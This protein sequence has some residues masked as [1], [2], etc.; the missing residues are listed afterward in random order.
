MTK[1]IINLLA[2]DPWAIKPEV[3]DELL[4]AYNNLAANL[5]ATSGAPLAALSGASGA[6]EGDAPYTLDGRVAVIDISGTI[7]RTGGH[8]RCFSW[9]GQDDIKAAVDAAISDRRAKAILLSFDSPGGVV[10]GLKELADHIAAQAKQ[11]PMYAY[12]DGLC[13]SAAYWLAS[14][15]GRIY[16]PVTAT[17]GSIGVVAVHTDRSGANTAAGLRITYIT[18][19]TWKAAGNADAPLSAQDKQYYQGRIDALHTIFKADVAARMPVNAD[20]PEKWGDGQ[21]FLAEEAR[22]LGLLTGIVSDRQALIAQIHKEI[23]MDKAKLASEHP[24]LLAEIEREATANA[25]AKSKETLTAALA[26]QAAL[27]AAIAGDEM[28]AKVAALVAAGVTA[29]QVK[30]MRAAGFDLPKAE[31][32]KAAEA[33]ESDSRKEVLAALKAATPAPVAAN[34][35][36]KPTPD[37][38]EAAI[39]AVAD[40]IAKM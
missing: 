20:L 2:D 23:S 4:A 33:A 30:A 10:A 6:S 22:S 19:G 5:G 21:V 12:A 37:D 3:L 31:A 26:N 16:A 11:K 9:T 13:A 34:P 8:A 35:Q 38:E 18:G 32:P 14:A 28:A 17:V 39:A 25:E 36:N 15:T 1:R 7:H 29:E 24:E 27:F 40:R